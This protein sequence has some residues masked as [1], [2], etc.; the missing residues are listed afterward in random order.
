MITY[1]KYDHFFFS[2]AW[3]VNEYF[4]QSIIFIV[5]ALV[6]TSSFLL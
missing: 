5:T 3:A 4:N 2:I 6:L 1:S